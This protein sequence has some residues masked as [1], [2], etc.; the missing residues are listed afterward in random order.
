M[1]MNTKNKIV[2]EL[3]SFLF[4]LLFVYAAAS[5]AL[6]FP[7]FK[8]QLAQ[9]PMLTA[10]S[11]WVAWFIPSIEILIAI[12]LTIVK[13][14]ILGLYASLALMVMFTAYIVAI[15][16]FSYYIPCSCGGILEDLNWE[17]HLVF[18]IFFVLLALIGIVLWNKDAKSERLGLITNN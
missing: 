14:R 11:D 4:I 18:N 2:I 9:S 6:D 12:S 15:L 8:V 10:F 17:E 13:T 5:K 7:K 3:I 1:T 16:N